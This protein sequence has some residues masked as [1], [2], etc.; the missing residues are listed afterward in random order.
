MKMTWKK[1]NLAEMYSH[2]MIAFLSPEDRKHK[3]IIYHTLELQASKHRG[4]LRYS[5]TRAFTH[6]E[7]AKMCLTDIDSLEKA[8]KEC[9][10]FELIM[11]EEDGTLIFLEEVE[12]TENRPT[13]G[14]MSDAERSKRYRERKKQKLLEESGMAGLTDG[15]SVTESSRDESRDAQSVTQAYRIDKKREDKRR[16][17]NTPQ[18]PPQGGA[19]DVCGGKDCS[20]SDGNDLFTYAAEHVNGAAGFAKPKPRTKGHDEYPL[21]RIRKAYD[22]ASIQT[23]GNM[24]EENREA[25]CQYIYVNAV[26]EN[27]RRTGNLPGKLRGLYNKWLADGGPHM[28]APQITR[29]ELAEWVREQNPQREMKITPEMES[30]FWDWLVAVGFKNGKGLRMTKWNIGNTI[31]AWVKN[32]RNECKSESRQAISDDLTHMRGLGVKPWGIDYK[33]D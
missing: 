14:A 11:E 17:Y 28:D 32:H 15:N 7:L 3:Y 1:A 5:E 24:T 25:F 22:E 10:E 16:D 8:L 29:E 6:E 2:K 18:K 12:I 33:K 31:S 19:D 23:G 13:G 26:L 21:E 9:K 30:G 20:Q 4:V 27:D